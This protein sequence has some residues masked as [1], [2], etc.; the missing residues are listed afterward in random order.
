[1]RT[2]PGVVQGLVTNLDDPQGLGRIQVEFP[3]LDAQYRSNWAPIATPLTGGQRGQF[4][5]PEV[6][7]EALVAFEH[8]DFDHPFVVGFLWNGVDTPPETELKNRVIL[9]PGGHT[10]RFED[11]DGAKKVVLKSSDG[12]QV[13]IDDAAREIT[14]TDSDAR[15]RILIQL[16]GGNIKVEAAAQVTV[17]APQISLVE[18]STHPLVFGDLLLAYLNQLV[19]LF[20]SHTHPFLATPAPVF[21][22]ATPSLISTRVTTG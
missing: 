5:M 13:V 11:K 16:S 10:L 12:H 9:T 6:G 22:P 14:I 8:G 15:N 21:T 20:N 18:D 17:E 4:F 7:D 1:M 19:A 3:W 2:I